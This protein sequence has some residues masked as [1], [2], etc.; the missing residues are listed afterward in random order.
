MTVTGREGPALPG[1]DVSVEQLTHA[2][3]FGNI[4]FDFLQT[5]GGP[6]PEGADLVDGFG[7][8]TPFDHDGL[9]DAWLRLFNLA[10]LPFYWGRY[11]PR[12]SQPDRS[13]VL[14]TANWLGRHDVTV[15]GHP[16]VWHTSQ[17]S[18][19]LGRGLAEVEAL[20]RAHIREVVSDFAGTIDLWDA[21]NES[22]I[23][24]A[25]ANGDN[26]I[27][28]LAAARG[29]LQMI[30]L[31]FEEARNANPS[32]RLVINDFD[33]SPKYEHAIEE[34]LDSGV[35]I[36]AIGLQT[37]MH[38]GYRGEDA[39]LSVVDR[40][41][42]FGIPLQMTETTLVSGHLMPTSVRDLNDYRI[43]N[44]PSTPEG[45]ER[46]AREVESHY[47]SLFA[48]P[49]IESITYWG[50]TDAGS[51]LGAPVGFMRADGSM[52]PS[53]YTLEK[54]IHDEW[55]VPKTAIRT[56]EH[57]NLRLSACAG[58]YLVSSSVGSATFT[59]QPGSHV[60]NAR[61]EAPRER[62]A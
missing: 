30:R 18:W 48:H 51:W 17:P 50:F 5:I 10:V 15:K 7:G 38:Q 26:A 22:V 20:L 52:K 49:A 9:A 42:R 44:W 53:Y 21:I 2:F 58:S 41:A 40:F 27:T 1:L 37:H 8:G 34:A 43:P 6:D 25:F 57:G 61:I 3:G 4:G 47:R 29:R 11:E 54:L 62:G 56:D 55:W 28:P 13:R 31:A 16:L 32:A 46:Q 12:Q 33:L 45:E 60:V 35:G 36:D 59:I 19:L 14:T 24:P 23:M 39:I